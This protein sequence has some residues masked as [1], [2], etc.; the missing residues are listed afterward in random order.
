M[1]TMEE[2]SAE[3]KKEVRPFQIERG[4]LPRGKKNVKNR[5]EQMTGKDLSFG[6]VFPEGDRGRKEFARKRIW[7]KKGGSPA[8]K[9]PTEGKGPPWEKKVSSRG[10]RMDGGG[11]KRGH[12]RKKFA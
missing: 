12:K 4:L 7:K 9:R 1:K 8:R 3:E 11:D 10:K 2:D 6:G 5:L